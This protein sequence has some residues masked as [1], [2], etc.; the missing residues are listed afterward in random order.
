[1]PEK[2]KKKLEEKEVLTTVSEEKEMEKSE[3]GK[4]SV[5]LMIIGATIVVTFIIMALVAIPTLLSNQQN[6]IKE[7][8]EKDMVQSSSQA[9]S[10][11]RYN[12]AELEKIKQ[13][14]DRKAMEEKEK[15]ETDTPKYIQFRLDSRV[16][17]DRLSAVISTDLIRFNNSSL[18]D[19]TKADIMTRSSNVAKEIMPVYKELS[20]KSKE[21][22]CAKVDDAYKSECQL[23][24][25]AYE[26]NLS[27]LVKY[28]EDDGRLR[29]TQENF[30][31]EVRNSISK[32]FESVSELSRGLAR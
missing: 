12:P 19:E 22:Q 11:P 8:K 1:M 18:N 32:N 9:S 26:D 6:Q 23:L 2:A 16:S 31:L 27:G 13:E 28:F 30:N 15:F 3:D 21:F 17:L 24:N 29:V 14:E 20:A 4:L 7:R 5:P 10:G 25:L